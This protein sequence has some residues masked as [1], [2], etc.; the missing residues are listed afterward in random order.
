MTLGLCMIVKDEADVLGRCLQSVA[1]LF[2]EIVVADTGSSDGTK[3]I[4]ARFGARVYGFAWQD[5]FAAARNFSFSKSTADYIAWLDADDVVEPHDLPAWHALKRGLDGSADAYF[6]PYRT[7]IDGRGHAS[8]VYYRERVLRRACRFL[9]QGAVHEAV[10]VRGNAVYGKAAVTHKK[11]A[12]RGKAG[13]GSVNGI[14]ADR[15]DGTA[16]GSAGTSR[17]DGA[18]DTPAGGTGGDGSCAPQTHETGCVGRNL[19]IYARQFAKGAR[20]TPRDVFYFAR[21]LAECG[22]PS[23]AADVFTYFLQGEGWA[24][25]KIEACRGLAACQRRLGRPAKELAALCQSF[26]YA[27]PRPETCCDLGAFFMRRKD[28]KQ[29]IFWFKLAVN[30]RSDARS[31]AFVCP[32][33]SGY[34]PYLWMCVCYDRLGDR[35]RAFWCNEQ[36][37]R[38]RPDDESVAFNR[39]Y[40]ARLSGTKPSAP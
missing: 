13:A 31:G 25:N 38:F 18:G 34:I 35:E 33:C 26:A 28:W 6:L 3:D 5:D 24:E 21:E 4:A 1:G 30:E 40:F 15:M 9:W 10:A 2:D 32:D 19:R 22:L 12:Y 8:L 29:A 39:R 7:G 37:A 36:A 16:A 14:G 20:P 27:P 17:A 11:P 23:A